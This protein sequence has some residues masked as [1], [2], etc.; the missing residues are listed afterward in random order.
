MP[1]DTISHALALLDAGRLP[2]AQ[3]LCHRILRQTPNHPAAHCGFC[4]PPDSPEQ[5]AAA[6]LEACNDPD[7][8]AIYG[9]NARH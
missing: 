2:D 7:R 5:M 9:R 1:P 4:V 8:L 6:F 3:A